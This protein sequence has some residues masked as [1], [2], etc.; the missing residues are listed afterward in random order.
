MSSKLVMFALEDRMSRE[1]YWSGFGFQVWCQLLTH[2][3]RS[4]ADTLLLVDEPEIYLH[5][6][7]QRQLLSIL[8]DA[9]PSVV[10]A[11]HS[12][13]IMAEA[14]PNEILLVDKRKRT[15]L[16][17]KDLAG[18][19]V[20]MGAIGSLQNV[21]LMQ[22]ARN[23]KVVFVE[24]LQ[25]FKTIR[26]FARRAGLNELAA[27]AD[28]TPVESGG[29]SSWERVKATAWGIERTLGGA[30]AIGAIFDRDYLCEEEVA[31]V[32]AQLRE[33]L[34]C[35]HIHGAKEIE[36]YL[37]VPNVLQRALT[38]AVRERRTSEPRQVPEVDVVTQLLARVTDTMRAA[39]LAD[40]MANRARYFE[41]AKRDRATIARETIAWFD[42]RWGNLESRLLIVPGKETLHSLR[43][44]IQK[45]FVVS[46][47]DIR[48]I[49]EFRR[50]EIPADLVSILE[51]LELFRR[52]VPPS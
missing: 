17:L 20:A 47:T 16:R 8:R 43:E 33:H 7:L 2:I 22:L 35:A 52:A 6:D 26:R 28:L 49:D 1:L 37:L 36:N 38:K 48:I 40:Y 10:L 23:R 4:S 30:I 46:L 14:D 13:E 11:T 25:D 32:L 21:T 18:V 24:G 12:A 44:E 42:E 19:Q 9:G 41:K 50:D 15:P 27:G 5:P 31:S 34:Q 39:T 3:S 45:Q 29:F 51:A